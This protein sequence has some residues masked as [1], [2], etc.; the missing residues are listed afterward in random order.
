MRDLT[1]QSIEKAKLLEQHFGKEFTR[2][3]NF[4]TEFKKFAL[5]GNVLDLAIGVVI[6]AAFGKIVTSLVQDII[7]GPL[8]LLVGKGSLQNHFIALD[9]K[10]YKTIEEASA[11]KA[12]LLAYG[13]FAQNIIDFLIVA[14]VIFITIRYINKISFLSLPTP[15][16]TK[17][18]PHCASTIP[19]KAVRCA[20]CTQAV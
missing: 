2:G 3:K 1:T 15:A 10:I 16:P 17:E 13:R 11:A 8:S 19:A 14:F 18:C 7:S 6:G 4:L 5:R 9:H 12:P 20:H